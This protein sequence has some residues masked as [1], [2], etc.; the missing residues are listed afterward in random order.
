MKNKNTL[1]KDARRLLRSQELGVLSTH[2]KSMEGYPFGSVTTYMS[3][4][5]GEPIFYISDLAQHTRNI[6]SNPKISL[7]AYSG[8][9]SEDDANANARLTIL[10]EAVQASEEES[11]KIAQRFYRLFPS[12][13]QYKNVHDFQFYILKCHKVRYIGGFGEIHWIS[14][15]DWLIDTPDWTNS[16]E[17]MIQHMNEDHQDAMQLI[18]KDKL[19]ISANSV[20][21]LALNPDGFFIKAD[22]HKPLFIEFPD[23]ALSSGSIRTTLVNMT[24][25]ARKNPD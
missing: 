10:G 22:Q 23:T 7:I 12:S 14:K 18:L 8:D 17:G 6:N 11:K 25:E 21:M 15:D 13:E 3:S 4:V 2:S 24:N 16:E 9:N 1:I 5:N 19:N 20:E